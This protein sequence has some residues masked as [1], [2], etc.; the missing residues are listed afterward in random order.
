MIN[1]VFQIIRLVVA[2]T[3]RGSQI[4][5]ESV[6]KRLGVAANALVATFTKSL[7]MRLRESISVLEVSHGGADGSL[8][9]EILLPQ[10]GIII[11]AQGAAILKRSHYSY[12]FL[13]NYLFILD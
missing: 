2:I 9:A 5:G 3:L 4:L 6:I 10:L 7:S 11:V 12:R 8:L 1:L 13:S